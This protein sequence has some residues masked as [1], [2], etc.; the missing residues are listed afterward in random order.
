M[1]SAS[2]SPPA[3]HYPDASTL[4]VTAFNVGM[5]A[6]NS[7]YQSQDEKVEE[8][9]SHVRMWLEERP[10]VV[11]LNEIHPNIGKKLQSVLQQ[12]VD[13]DIAA[14]ESNCILWRTLQ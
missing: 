9:A 3:P 5:I 2:T 14:H 8:L 4:G 10:A 12:E 13:V 6:E 1:V 7:F 11:G